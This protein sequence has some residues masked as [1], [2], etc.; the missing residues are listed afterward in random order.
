MLRNNKS[1]KITH[2]NK[3]SKRLLYMLVKVPEGL[4]MPNSRVQS[5]WK[6]CDVDG[7]G[8]INFEERAAWGWY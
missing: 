5:F 6:E 1:H 2:K 3:N 4:D 8:A 7:S